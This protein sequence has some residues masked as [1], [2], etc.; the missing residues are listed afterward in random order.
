[1]VIQGMNVTGSNNTIIEGSGNHTNN[2]SPT[3][4]NSGASGNYGASGNTS[5]IVPTTSPA[6]P[7]PE[8]V[9]REEQQKSGDEG[10]SIMQAL[11]E[12]ATGKISGRKG[13]GAST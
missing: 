7:A 1:M 4:D 13:S 3:S 2:N 8:P 5:P 6:F 11:S 10:R 12:F 9:A